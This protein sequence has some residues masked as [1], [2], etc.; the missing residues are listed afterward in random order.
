[1]ASLDED[2][3]EPLDHVDP[4]DSPHGV[5]YENVVRLMKGCN[6]RQHVSMMF[7]VRKKDLIKVTICVSNSHFS[8]Y[9]S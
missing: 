8:I 4:L 5:K 9:L 2:N 7:F 1:M 6:K 3:G